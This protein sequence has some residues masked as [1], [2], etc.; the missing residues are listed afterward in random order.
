MN[1]FQENGTTIPISESCIEEERRKA[2]RKI[3]S[4]CALVPSLK[5]SIVYDYESPGD[6][7]DRIGDSPLSGRYFDEFG[8]RIDDLDG[9]VQQPFLESVANRRAWLTCLEFSH[10]HTLGVSSLDDYDQQ[11]AQP[12]STVDEDEDQLWSR[13][14]NRLVPSPRLTSLVRGQASDVNTLCKPGEQL[15][16]PHSLRPHIWPRLTGS[17]QKAR[18][19][20]GRDPPIT[21]T[22]LVHLSSS[23]AMLSGLQIEKD[24][25][26]TLPNNLCFSSSNST[27]ISRLRRVLRALAWLYVDVGYCQGMGLI[28]ANLLLCLEEEI[29]FWM[30]CSIVEDLLP[31][32]YYSSLSLLGVQADQAVLCHLL[33]LYLPQLDKLLKEHEIGKCMYFPLTFSIQFLVLFQLLILV[34]RNLL[35]LWYACSLLLYGQRQSET[36]PKHGDPFLPPETSISQASVETIG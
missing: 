18:E 10:T 26:R 12:G 24:L 28:A 25:L 36:R 8:F 23:Q 27:G 6:E 17:R 13:V 14:H 31:P 4:F 3:V 5:P 22:E 20:R 34:F 2:L 33:P 29:A 30:M 11:Y 32:S 16:I 9:P 15:G 1:G 21:Y 7:E 19:A 35:R